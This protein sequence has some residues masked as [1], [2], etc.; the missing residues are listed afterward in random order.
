MFWQ[1]K[2]ED[3]EQ[4][5][6]AQAWV[7]FEARH[8]KDLEKAFQLGAS[9]NIA[10]GSGL[11]LAQSCVQHQC[12]DLLPVLDQ[13]QANWHHLLLDGSSCLHL[14]VETGQSLWVKAMLERGVEVNLE[15]KMNQTA[16]HLAA[17]LGLSTMLVMLDQ[18]G[19]NWQA[20]DRLQKT[21]L[22]IL[23]QC[24][25]HTGSAWR[26]RLALRQEEKNEELS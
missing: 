3:K 25:P 26:R 5:I 17:K 7:A 18:A 21:P 4:R 23:M 1:S 12:Y 10:S 11:T 6:Q 14:S 19:A 13:Y 22:D 9:P 16:L 24:H 8:L 20:K 2:K 15:N